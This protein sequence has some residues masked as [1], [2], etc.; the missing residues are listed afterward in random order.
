MTLKKYT[1]L[2]LIF[3]CASLLTVVRFAFAGSCTSTTYGDS[4]LYHCSDGTSGTSTTYGDSTVHHFSDGTSGTSTTYGDSTIHHF[5]DGT[6]GTSSRFGATA[7]DQFEGSLDDDLD[8]S[9]D[10]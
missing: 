3:I 4:T 9:S 10:E 2:F 8:D 6:S 7:F 1:T 5:N